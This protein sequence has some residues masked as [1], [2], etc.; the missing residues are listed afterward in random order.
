MEDRAKDGWEALERRHP[1]GVTWAHFQWEFA[2][3]FFLQSYK[4]A[5]VE[6]FFRL[7]QK[8][9]SVTDYEE[10]FSE[11]VWLVPFIQENEE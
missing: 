6:E 9:M 8:S 1:E 7:E 5:R 11:L 10:K 2:N 4:D 3:R